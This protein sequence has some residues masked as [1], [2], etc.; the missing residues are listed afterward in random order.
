VD[1]VTSAILGRIVGT[2]TDRVIRQLLPEQN[3]I[4]QDIAEI[5]DEQERQSL[6]TMKAAVLHL[7]RGEFQRAKDDLVTALANTDSEGAVVHLLLAGADFRLGNADLAAR[8]LCQGVHLNPYLLQE[9]SW[10]ALRGVNWSSLLETPPPYTARP[11]GHTQ[12]RGFLSLPTLGPTGKPTWLYPLHSV[13]FASGGKPVLESF[14]AGWLH[15]LKIKLTGWGGHAFVHAAGMAVWPDLSHGRVVFSWVSRTE[16]VHT[17][18]PMPSL[19]W[20]C[21]AA[22]GTLIWQQELQPDE[23]LVLVTPSRVVIETESRTPMFRLL[24][25]AT[26]QTIRRMRPATFRTTFAPD[27]PRLSWSGGFARSHWRLSGSLYE[28]WEQVKASK[29]GVLVADLTDPFGFDHYHV[30]IRQV[31]AATTYASH[32]S[33]VFHTHTVIGRVPSDTELQA[34]V[35]SS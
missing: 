10:R 7:S 35:G 26:G 21:D 33:P 19:L 27:W 24:T 2:V 14:P 9:E 5:R 22:D 12:V 23:K 16:G 20:A 1:P 15:D 25:T 17:V 29:G 34:L 11:R 4:R 8:H 32:E 18:S 31:L 6:V 28:L 30:V 3:L 13:R